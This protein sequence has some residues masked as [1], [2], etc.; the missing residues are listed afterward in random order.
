M[1]ALIK[2]TCVCGFTGSLGDREF[3][4]HVDS[5]PVAQ[6]QILKRAT[7]TVDQ[8]LEKLQTICEDSFETEL[9]LP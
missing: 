9:T 1:S 7:Q 4:D 3:F 6:K 2:G 5:C 8:I